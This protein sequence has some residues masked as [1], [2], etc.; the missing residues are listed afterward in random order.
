MYSELV[1]GRSAKQSNKSLLINNN[2][3]P[4]KP[5]HI[6]LELVDDLGAFPTNPDQAPKPTRSGPPKNAP[7]CQKPWLKGS[8]LHV[9][10]RTH[11]GSGTL[12]AGFY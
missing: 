7:V 10:R 2:L 5:Y 8:G 1:E 3:R 11:R 6:F 12:P 4:P 9:R